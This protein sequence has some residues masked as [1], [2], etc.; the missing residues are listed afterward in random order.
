MRTP[1]FILTFLAAASV[2]TA[3]AANE[4]AAGP[5]RPVTILG[6]GDSLTER[7]DSYLPALAEL[8]RQAG[9]DF[10]LVGPH[11]RTSRFGEYRQAGF[12]GKNAAFLASHLEEIY[13][14]SPADIVL[15]QCGH[16]NFAEKKPVAGIIGSYEKMIS[17]VLGINP[18]A[19]IF[20]AQIVES[21][22]LPKY[23]Y[24]P[25]LNVALRSMVRSLADPRVEFVKVA[26]GFEWEKHT[27]EDKVH[28]NLAGGELMAR[29]WF[30]GI[31]KHLKAI[32]QSMPAS[33][34][35][36]CYA[37]LQ[38][39]T[40]RIGN[41][42]MERTFLWNGGNLITI[43]L[44]DKTAG[45]N[46]PSKAAGPDFFV[47]GTTTKAADGCF[48]V[49]R[50]PADGIKGERLEAEV[51]FS[52]EALQV[53]R[54]YRI[55]PT[56]K[57]LSC[58]TYL[59]GSSENLS[60][61]Q[62]VNAGDLKNIESNKATVSVSTLPLLDRFNL[63]GTH[64]NVRAVEFFDVTDRNNTLVRETDASSY[65]ETTYRGNLLFLHEKTVGAGIFVIKQSPVSTIQ[66][67]YPGADFSVD[68]SK[69]NVLGLG[70]GNYDL[71]ED[72]WTRAYGCA[73]GLYSGGERQ[74][75]TEL[76]RFQKLERAGAAQ[77]D[78]MIMV[79]TWGDRG[80][81]R[82]VNEAFCLEEIRRAG[83]LGIT[84]VQ[85][86][87]GWQSGKSANS[88][89]GG[90]FKNI[91]ANPNYWEPDPK[92]YPRGLKPLTDACREKGIELCL[93]FN[94][95]T[96]DHFADWEKDAAA[97]VKLYKNDGIRVFKIDGV[98]VADKLAEER[99]RMLFERVIDSTDHKALFNLDVTASRR[100]GYFYMTE[101][102]NIFL[103]NRYT[104]WGNYFPHWTLR[105]IWMLSRYVPAEKIQVEF[106]NNSRNP[107]KYA[108][109]PY[110]PDRYS[111]EYVFATSLAGQP[112]AWM[113]LSN[114]SE[115]AFSIA[116][117]IE[118]Y[119][120]VSR[121]FHSGT[122][123]PIGDEPSGNSWSGFQSLCG[124]GDRGYILLYREDNPSST[125]SFQLFVEPGATLVLKPV[126]SGKGKAA[127]VKADSEGRV[128]F[129]IAEPRDYAMYSYEVR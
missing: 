35:S 66:L 89:F 93:W 1:S 45:R 39:D 111:F 71:Q 76:R 11:S 41:S 91:W 59:K 123:L 46:W 102:G 42:E 40:L 19:K 38:A 56:S 99:L 98:T 12:S 113:E 96:Q 32:A 108:S 31:K 72:R 87:D 100:G 117:R 62:T 103:E 126:F 79:N 67:S 15:L 105:N 92:K 95:S 110:N 81:D 107:G 74:R 124:D 83:R 30:K 82:K 112:L 85:I 13:S 57:V 121:D 25:E 37:T 26:K 77:G 49:R 61:F 63:G 22:K 127:K 58:E 120:K 10:E 28:P 7:A 128:S 69:V 33:Q 78:E 53:K 43:S 60:R 18:E 86:D 54:I 2:L 29:N 47:P 24:I 104:D 6:V 109:S 97:L 68:F 84:H 17:T 73:V 36:V 125:H 50:L 122:I 27:I 101:Y 118:E 4:T 75:L 80:Q 20:V 129:K 34:E 106:L 14:G 16:N 90:S 21:G 48:Q 94:P 3:S 64:W 116:P 51:T 88:A 5:A 44:T 114:L 52:L 115:E 23:S 55:H 119:K 65:K 8:L 9:L 70:V